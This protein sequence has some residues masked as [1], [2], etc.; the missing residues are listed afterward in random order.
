MS[1]NWIK[2][3]FKFKIPDYNVYGVINK[4]LSEDGLIS[5][6]LPL[7][8]N[9]IEMIIQRLK[10]NENVDEKKREIKTIINF[11]DDGYDSYMSYILP[12]FDD[13][14]SLAKFK[15]C[16]LENMKPYRFSD[17]IKCLK[18]LE[19]EKDK[20]GNE[21]AEEMKKD[22]EEYIDKYLKDLVKKVNSAHSEPNKNDSSVFQLE[23]GLV[24]PRDLIDKMKTKISDDCLLY[25]IFIP[26][27]DKNYLFYSFD[28]KEL[29]RNDFWLMKH[30]ASQDDLE[31]YVE[32]VR[33]LLRSGVLS[34]EEKLKC[35]E[36]LDR[37]IRSQEESKQGQKPDNVTK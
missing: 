37:Y 2:N 35:K 17:A 4:I 16:L 12:F 14:K 3:A 8:Y 23:D 27:Q 9:E 5:I 29:V 10:E 33:Q 25:S 20:L 7:N 6:Y 24:I 11:K 34:K 36:N 26:E 19:D 1:K 22:I 21:F 18:I 31:A 30:L 15:Q 13:D 28:K 32:D